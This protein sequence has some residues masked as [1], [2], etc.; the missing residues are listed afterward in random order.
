MHRSQ[1]GSILVGALPQH[2]GESEAVTVEK[3]EWSR[4]VPHGSCPELCMCSKNMSNMMNATR[5]SDRDRNVIIIC[6]V[7]GYVRMISDKAEKAYV[8]WKRIAVVV[9]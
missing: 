1:T 6:E 9:I 8:K 7:L 4:L 3:S 2:R 5:W